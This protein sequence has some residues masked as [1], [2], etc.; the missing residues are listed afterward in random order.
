M[1]GRMGVGGPGDGRTGPSA[2]GARS[3]EAAGSPWRYGERNKSSEA[4][5]ACAKKS[6]YGSCRTRTAN[7]RRWKGGGPSGRRGKHRQGTRQNG[8]VT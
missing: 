5:A 2:G 1:R 7:R 8:P 4:L 3:E 6:R